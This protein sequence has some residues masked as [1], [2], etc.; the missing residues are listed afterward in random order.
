MKKGEERKKLR[1]AVDIPDGRVRRAA[2]RAQRLLNLRANL[3]T[4]LARLR[5]RNLTRRSSLEAESKRE[6]KDGEER[7]N[8]RNSVW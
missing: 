2:T 4:A 1:V 5:V 6:K 8:I 7:R 3:V